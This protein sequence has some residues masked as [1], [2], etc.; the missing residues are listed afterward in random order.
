MTVTVDFI[1]SQIGPIAPILL[2][3]DHFEPIR[4]TI[5]SAEESV[6]SLFNSIYNMVT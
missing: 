3:V 2:L 4:D 5:K 1:V 6:N